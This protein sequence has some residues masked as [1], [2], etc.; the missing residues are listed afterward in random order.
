MAT[1]QYVTSTVS[2]AKGRGTIGS[3]YTSG[4]TTVVLTAGHGAR[5]PAAGNYSV[6]L[7]SPTASDYEIFRVSSRSTDTLT[8]VGAQENTP[9]GNHAVGQDVIILAPTKVGFDALRGD[10]SSIDVYAN[11][12]STTGQ[13]AGNQYHPSD[14][15]DRSLIF[16][17]SAWQPFGAKIPQS[18]TG[19]SQ[20]A[21]IPL[22][23]W[24]IVNGAIVNDFFTDSIRLYVKE[25][26]TSTWRFYT[27]TIPSSNYT[28]YA[29][30]R[31]RFAQAALNYQSLGIYLSDGTKYEG[32]EMRSE[33]A[34]ADRLRIEKLNSYSSDNATVF[35]P[36]SNLVTA[37][38]LAVKIVDDGTHRTWYYWTAGAWVQALQESSHTFLTE[39]TAGFG[40]TS[41]VG[42]NYCYAE[43]ELVYWSVE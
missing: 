4:D 37:E 30:I 38:M 3:A 21:T 16:D 13:M 42:V 15:I 26:G 23:G 22:T 7:G 19:A 35:G 43:A 2:N 39:T 36:T 12:P 40:G 24:S 33:S 18:A 6:A 5:Y 20:A 32:L 11:L 41:V 1:E 9:A 25:D 27:R 8:G 34:G 14:R 28:L 10:M 31:M 29:A 17:G